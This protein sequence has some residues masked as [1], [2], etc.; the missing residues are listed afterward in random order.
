[1]NYI[2]QS[3]EEMY[4][5]AKR[6]YKSKSKQ[7]GEYSSNYSSKKFNENSQNEG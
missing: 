1:M 2:E 7:S 4:K 3:R 5:T 6:V